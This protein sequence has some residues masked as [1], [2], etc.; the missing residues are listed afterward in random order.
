MF[1]RL[2][3]LIALSAAVVGFGGVVSAAV[4]P[5]T[6]VS[7]PSPFAAC[8][9]GG[10][11]TIN[12]NAEVEPFLA[13][14]PTDASHMIGVFQQD[15]WDN[16]GAHGLVAAFTHDG[17]GT[18]GETS[19][20]FSLCSGGT[21]A[22]GGDFERASDPWVT[23]APNGDAY[24]IAL[25]LNGS[26]FA[27]GVLVSKQAHGTDTWSEPVTLARDTSPFLSHDKESITADPTDSRYVYAVWDRARKPGE[28]NSL[29][30]GHS[31][32]F[33]GDLMF[34][35]T[36]DSG[37]SWSPARNLLP[38]NAN[39][40]TSGN[41]VSVLPDGTLVDVFEFA[42]GSGRQGSPNQF[43]ESLMRSTDKGLTWSPKID[44]STD[45]SVG[46]RDPDTGGP[47]RTGA[48]LP[49]VA[50]APDG[51]LYVVWADSR[52]SGG[53][54]DD[55][56]LSK[57]TD[58]GLTW[59]TPIKVNQTPVPVAAFTPAVDVAGNGTVAVTYYDFRN[60]TPDTSTLPTDAFAVFSHDGGQTFGGE[61][62]LTPTS[63]D[64]DLAP[65][66]GGLF[67]GDYVG[68]SHVGSTFV[69]FY[70]QTVSAS[71]PTDIFASFVP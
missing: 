11:G 62:R 55:I 59:S 29:N 4:S 65:R 37:A 53:V 6:L 39:L 12:V 56:A 41:I 13:V 35:R 22:N 52:F 67:L 7:G 50:V 57:S 51:T 70:T 25:T 44:I 60:N 3:L 47:V 58:G 64:L 43:S 33:R 23:F 14:D 5:L 15:R 45:Q 10:P 48:G 16:G 17:G 24:Q 1:R 49:D 71:N 20:H 40:F 19:A 63:F 34:S 61:M 9:I 27:T 68:L 32:A 36:A 54:R 30:A 66:A 28:N 21:V 38:T 46:V 26:D 8:T 42:K 69:P 18:W 31:F 2:S